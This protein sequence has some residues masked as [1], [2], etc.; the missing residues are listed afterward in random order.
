MSDDSSLP[1]IL[2]AAAL[3]KSARHA[4]VFSGAGLSTPSGIQDFRSSGTGLWQ[5]DD[6]MEVSSLSTFRRNPQRFYTW[7]RPLAKSM[8][9]AQPNA[10]HTALARLEQA[11]LVRALITQNIDGLHQRA[12][13]RVVFEVHGSL[14]TLSC[15]ACR[16]TFKSSDYAVPFIEEGIMPRCRHC[17]AVLKPDIV[18]FEQ[19]LPLETWQQAERHCQQADL[20]L[21]VG[22]SLQVVPAAHLPALAL[23]HGARLVILNFTPTY[24]DDDADVVLREDLVVSVPAIAQVV[25]D[26]TP[27]GT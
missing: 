11:G 1:F 27:Q 19:M 18:L 5:R 16:R 13:S 7:L 26:G 12:G 8:W 4:V 23:Q 22:S 24:L 20:M 17:Q 3:L 14:D 15:L 9:A 21:V 25:L 2:Q 10:A 6:P